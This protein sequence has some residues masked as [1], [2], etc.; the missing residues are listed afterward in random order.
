MSN[1]MSGWTNTWTLLIKLMTE[2]RITIVSVISFWSMYESV[3]L[4]D[5]NDVLKFEGWIE[6]L[7]GGRAE[8]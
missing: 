3:R 4:Y 5:T 6:Y 1:T 2:L 8:Y 7:N